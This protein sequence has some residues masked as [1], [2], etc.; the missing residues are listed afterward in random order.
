M[1]TGCVI[2][3][4]AS[5]EQTWSPNMT[6]FIIGRLFVGIGQGFVL[7]TG[8]TYIAEIAPANV[9]GKIMSFWQLMFAVG[10]FIVYCEYKLYESL[11]FVW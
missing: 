8:P 7:P 11:S 4:L 1:F 9:R 3:I 6:A 10:N 5:I 2:V